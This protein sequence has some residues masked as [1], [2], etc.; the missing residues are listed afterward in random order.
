MSTEIVAFDGLPLT[1]S[2]SLAR[3]GNKVGGGSL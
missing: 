2:P 3:A 1:I